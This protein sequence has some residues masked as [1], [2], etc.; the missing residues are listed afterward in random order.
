MMRFYKEDYYMKNKQIIKVLSVLFAVTIPVGMLCVTANA[1]EYDPD[2]FVAGE[3]PVQGDDNDL[4]SSYSS[5]EQGYVTDIR[6]LFPS[7]DK[8]SKQLLVLLV[9]YLG[10]TNILTDEAIE[11]NSPKWL[12]VKYDNE[13]FKPLSEKEHKQA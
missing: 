9:N 6:L 13:K 3:A 1:A 5:V 11:E 4:P 2:T 8:L 10:R 12:C 7:A